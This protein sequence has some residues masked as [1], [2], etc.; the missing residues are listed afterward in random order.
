MNEPSDRFTRFVAALGLRDAT[1]S[2]GGWFRRGV[3]A[4][5]ALPNVGKEDAEIAGI[6][7]HGYAE[8]ADDALRLAGIILSDPA[9]RG[10]EQEALKLI[11]DGADHATI[12][13]KLRAYRPRDASLVVELYP[14][15]KGESQ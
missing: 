13:A 11:A 6:W 3:V 2:A 14:Q 1:V 8:G 15:K 4:F 12:T 7:A 9:C 5:L 10:R